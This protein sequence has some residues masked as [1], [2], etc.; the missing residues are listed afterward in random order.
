MIAING[1]PRSYNYYTHIPFMEPGESG[2]V[3]FEWLR[4]NIPIF[5][6]KFGNNSWLD[7]DTNVYMIEYRF[8]YEQDLILFKLVWE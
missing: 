3:K 8:E 5:D 2:N 4:N 7:P 1:A 6:W